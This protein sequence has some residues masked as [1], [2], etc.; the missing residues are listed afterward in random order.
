MKLRAFQPAMKQSIYSAWAR[1]SQCLMPVAPTGS[2]K[3]VLMG[4]ILHE[5]SVPSCAIAHRQELVS[6]ISL[7][8]SRYEVPYRIIAPQQTIK[9][10]IRLDMQENGQSL[11]HPRAPCAVAG[12]DT[13][14]NHNP[15]DPWL[16]QCQLIVTDEGH[17]VLQTNKWGK[18]NAL[19]NPA[20]KRLLFTAHALR[21][22]GKGLGR[23]ADGIVDEL[24]VGPCA[25]DLINSGYLTD[26]RLVVAPKSIDVSQIGY[27]ADGDFNRA[28]LAKATHASST[29][30]G[31]IVNAYR[32]F[33]SG[34][35]GVTFAVDVEAATE[36][37][38]AYRAA[39]VPAEVVT[40]KT[41]PALR[42]SILRRFRAREILQL[43]N[44]DLFGEG[45]DLP[46]IEVVSMAR[47]TASF[48]LY[49]QQFG[50]ALR[51]MI[52]AILTGAWDTFTDAE[53]L[54]FIAASEKPVAIVIDHVGNWERHGLPDKRR[55]YSLDRRDRLARSTAVQ[56][57]KACLNWPD[58]AHVY[59]RYLP[60]C[61]YCGFAPVP[62]NRSAPE[63]VDGDL[64]E[65]DPAVLA[66][67]RGKIDRIDLA[68]K[69]NPYGD[70]AT[71]RHIQNVH[72]ERQQMQATLR[73]TIATWAGWQ[74]HLGLTDSMIYRKFFITFGTDVMTAQTLGR[75]EADLLN[76][77]I[78]A[79]LLI[80]NIVKSA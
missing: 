33:A 16:K 77:K 53:R 26:Y 45:F 52:S 42:A 66:V 5:Q 11:Y 50:R 30:I 40:A 38:Q 24:I 1:G 72:W 59:E 60:A 22:D 8:L 6:Q 3:T 51:L 10:I 54:A 25:R 39:G 76:V 32:K 4:N 48:Q 18:A 62:S 37:A 15:D 2:G 71:T 61:P 17:H 46:A 20:A 36:Y 27:S 43:V 41:P 58:C 68:P 64:F 80:D 75:K 70:S 14:N 23:T 35:L 31:D 55:E 65:L 19:F 74:K 29:I 63:H 49:A 13:L 7:A 78:N 28:Q 57:L 34:K 67:L 56:L 79:A 73:D 9:E 21:A 44:V 47:A 69:S 12:V